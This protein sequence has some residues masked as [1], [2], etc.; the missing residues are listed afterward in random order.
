MRSS[1]GYFFIFRNQSMVQVLLSQAIISDTR[2]LPPFVYSTGLSK[3]N[4]P[5]ANL[6]HESAAK[7]SNVLHPLTTQELGKPHSRHVHSTQMH[8]IHKANTLTQYW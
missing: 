8:L 7:E 4:L 5:D 3:A 6:Y 2:E 1:L